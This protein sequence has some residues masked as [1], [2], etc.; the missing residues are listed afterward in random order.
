MDRSRKNNV[1]PHRRP[2]IFHVLCSVVLVPPPSCPSR[3]RSGLSVAGGP[4]WWSAVD[5]CHRSVHLLDGRGTDAARPAAGARGRPFPTTVAVDDPLPP[6][7]VATSSYQTHSQ[8]YTVPH[9]NTLL[10]NFD[11]STTLYTN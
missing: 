3:L 2:T 5:G 9:K 8:T 11:I 7:P 10:R 4:R 6:T 1:R